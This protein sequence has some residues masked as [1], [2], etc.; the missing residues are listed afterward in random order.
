MTNRNVDIYE[1][2]RLL[3]N[4][5]D[6]TY[7]RFSKQIRDIDAVLGIRYP[8]GPTIISDHCIDAMDLT[9]DGTSVEDYLKHL[10]DV[11]QPKKKR[12]RN[13]KSYL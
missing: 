11:L 2:L 10:S 13:R 8:K 7:E 12:N 9:D 1:E 4:K 5:I 6:N 3:D